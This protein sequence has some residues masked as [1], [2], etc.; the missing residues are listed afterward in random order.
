MTLQN[1]IDTARNLIESSKN[2]IMFFDTDTDG[3]TSFIQL[4][5]KYPQLKEGYPISKEEDQQK[6]AMIKIF[7]EHDMVI[8]F[9]TPYVIEDFFHEINGRQVVWADHHI[10]I[11][12]HI[13]ENKDN[14]IHFVNPMNYEESDQRCSCFLAYQITQLPENL[15]W[16]AMGSVAD[17]YLLDVVVDFY[18]YDK[19]AFN[20]LFKITEEKRE[21]LFEFINTYKFNDETQTE[22]RTYWIQY[23]TYECGLIQYKTFFDILFKFK[24]FEKTQKV[25]KDIAKMNLLDFKVELLNGKIGIYEKYQEIMSEY[26]SVQSK[27][28]TAKDEELIFIEH[29]DKKISFNRQ[30]SEEAAFRK[31]NYKAIVC[32]YTKP[33]MSMYSCSIR[34][35]DFDINKMLNECIAGLEGKGGGH[36]LASGCIVSKADFPIFKK[37][38][39]EY[40]ASHSE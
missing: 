16:V 22:T 26:K 34:G 38:I 6:E 23:L 21:E 9:D 29:E 19:S 37:R 30:L 11:N 18:N 3:S 24:K 39:I 12:Q 1:A 17:F 20:T 27:I 40:V 14:K 7:D 35:K 8:F 33:I 13:L 25:L 36:K 15:V 28:A 2:P 32:T 31:K 5:R 10:P 4:K